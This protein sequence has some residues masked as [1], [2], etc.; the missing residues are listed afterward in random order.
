MGLEIQACPYCF[1]R[2]GTHRAGCPAIGEHERASAHREMAEILRRLRLARM[3]SRIA[4]VAGIIAVIA[5]V[6]AMTGCAS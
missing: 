1:I 5:S 3:W 2:G 4:I 6:V